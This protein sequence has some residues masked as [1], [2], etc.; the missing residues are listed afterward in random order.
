MDI[1]KLHLHW[2]ER[3]YKGKTYRSYSLA[4]AYRDNGKRRKEIVL[5]LGKLTEAEVQ[6]WQH[7]LHAAKHPQA[8]V[9]TLEHLVVTH[10][11]AYLDVAVVNAVWDA[12]HLN[13]VFPQTG[14]RQLTLASIARI[15]T[16]NRCLEPAAK[17]KTPEWFR[18]TALP[19]L[20]RIP[21]AQVNASRIF[22]ELVAIEQQK[23]ALCQHLFFQFCRREPEAMR[24]VFYDLSSTTFSGSHCLLMNWGYCKEGYYTHVVLALVVNRRGLPF[25]WEVLPGKTSDV[26]TIT[27]LL[28]RL[29]QRFQDIQVTLTFDRG[30]V[31]DSN[32]RLLEAAEIKYIS[33][34]DKDQIEGLS[35]IDFHAFSHLEPQ[36]IES[37]AE[38][39]PYFTKLTSRLFYREVGGSGARRYI[40][41]LSPQLFKEQRH[42][43][44]EAVKTFRRVVD[45]LN[46]DL[47]TAQK[48][49]QHDAT[50][51]KFTQALQKAKLTACVQVTLQPLH[52]SVNT[53]SAS[54]RVRTWQGTIEV[55]NT[56]LRHAG[57]LDGFWL[58]VTNHTEDE[59]EH[60]RWP[61]QDVIPPYQE[62]TVIEAAF[63]DIKSFVDIR[64][65]YVW[66][67]AHVKAHYTLCVLA[68]L[69]NRTLSNADV[70]TSYQPR[71]RPHSAYCV[72]RTL[73]S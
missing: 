61:A 56:A 22:R 4:R 42:A 9:T 49:R 19:W 43:R 34:M 38:R 33:A 8:F 30:M 6:W 14:K 67:E 54:R 70:T 36:H 20:L 46:A 53:G 17:S 68:Y 60:G 28:D 15:L 47:R 66:T 2:G 10:R 51:K 31:S 37:Q 63:R 12:L 58:L 16:L 73:V 71:R 48:S 11:Y 18:R 13:N 64:P 29:K 69:I 26:T 41:C 27:W 44:T 21:V 52:L 50:L 55:D 24:T 23:E 59:D 25:Y 40:L 7:V 57:R 32:L 1:A 3:R 39:L 35:G 65:V 62:K 72:S 5:K 45:E